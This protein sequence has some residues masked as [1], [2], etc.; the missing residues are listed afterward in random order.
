MVKNK[1]LPGAKRWKKVIMSE[2][3]Q[4]ES[5]IFFVRAQ[6]RYDELL[7]QAYHY[8]NKALRHHFE[9][10]ILPAIAAY[11]ILLMEGKDKDSTT[12]ILDRLLEANTEPNRRT[13]RFWGRFPF[14]FDLI[15]LLL[16]PMMAIQYPDRWNVEWPKLGPDVV[17]LNCRSCFYLDVLTEY[18]YPELTPHFCRLDDLLAA[19]AAPSVHFERTQTLARGGTICDFRYLR[20]RRQ[21]FLI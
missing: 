15:K 17:G 8:E 10:K 9:D 16:K 3:R 20:V 14:F 4:D 6:A 13:Y 1:Q 7:H 12:Q 18:G 19:E 21:R 11:S 2:R 5:A